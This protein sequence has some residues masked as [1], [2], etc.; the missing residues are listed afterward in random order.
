MKKQKLKN[1]SGITLLE[2]IRLK[3]IVFYIDPR[4]SQKLCKEP[5]CVR[6]LFYKSLYVKR[7]ILKQIF[8]LDRCVVKK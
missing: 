7:H 3:I 2:V 4:L 1:N 5:K 8:D 6:F